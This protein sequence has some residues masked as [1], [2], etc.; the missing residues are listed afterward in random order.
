MNWNILKVIFYMKIMIAEDEKSLSK[1]IKLY[2]NREN[3]DVTVVDDGLQ[4]ISMLEQDTFD[5][6]ILDWMMPGASGIEICEWMKRMNIPTKILMLTAKSTTGD[7]IVGL[8]TSAD[9]YIKKPFDMN[10]L[11]LR[12]QKLLNLPDTF[13]CGSVILNR[14][15]KQVTVFGQEAILSK[16]EY[17][18]LEYF[19]KNQGIVLSREQILD[20]VWG[21]SYEGDIRT[22]DTHIRRL[23]TK[24]GSEMIVTH[25]GQGY[26]MNKVQT[27]E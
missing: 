1:I 23:R 22:V 11:L 6:V 27:N 12:V 21:I 25:K 13:T 8:S 3:Y 2:L 19:I 9:N 5:L 14:E 24:V 7:E 10:V 26:C 4:A 15:S 20:Q 17:D 16:K 18:L